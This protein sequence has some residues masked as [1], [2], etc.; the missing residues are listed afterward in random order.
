MLPHVT[1][2]VTGHVTAFSVGICGDNLHVTT[3]YCIFKN[4]IHIYFLKKAVTCGNMLN[5]WS[6]SYYN[7]SNMY[8]NM[9]GNMW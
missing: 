6:K 3:C 4:N 1:A 9:C 5:F 7:C 2:H 8:S